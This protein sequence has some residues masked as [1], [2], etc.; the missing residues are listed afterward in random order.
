MSYDQ[1]LQQLEVDYQRLYNARVFFED[2]RYA[3]V[4]P[5][6]HVPDACSAKALTKTG[7]RRKI[8]HSLYSLKN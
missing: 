6:I 7:I 3:G 2:S 8:Q 1:V 5:F 4:I